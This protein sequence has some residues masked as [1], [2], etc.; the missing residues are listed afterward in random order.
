MTD[1]HF[2]EDF[3]GLTEGLGYADTTALITI[4]EKD[5]RS[6]NYYFERTTAMEEERIYPLIVSLVDAHPEG[7]DL[8][9]YF[10]K[11]WYDNTFD[12]LKEYYDSG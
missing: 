10:M 3:K 6:I 8:I 1:K 11:R 12:E 2:G 9:N 5:R 4:F 7:I